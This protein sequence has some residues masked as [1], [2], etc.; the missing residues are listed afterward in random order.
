MKRCKAK[1]W[2]HSKQS[3]AE[4]IDEQRKKAGTFNPG[5]QP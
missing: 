2:R 3:Q 4:A 1:G 5:K